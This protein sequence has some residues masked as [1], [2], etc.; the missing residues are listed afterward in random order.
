METFVLVMLVFILPIF[1]NG[2]VAKRRGKNPIK[3]VALSFF[4]PFL[5]IILM[6]YLL[7]FDK[8]KNR[9]IANLLAFE[10]M[11]SSTT[12]KITG[13][14]GMMGGILF[15]LLIMIMGLAFLLSTRKSDRYFLWVIT[16]GGIFTIVG[17]LGVIGHIKDIFSGGK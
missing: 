8:M 4:V 6:F 16:G 7:V 12:A 11:K 15:S 5:G 14:L 3:Y 13:I 17:I 10:I 2:I 9:T 1:F